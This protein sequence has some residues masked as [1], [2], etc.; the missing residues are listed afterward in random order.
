TASPLAQ[1]IRRWQCGTSTAKGFPMR[2][3]QQIAIATLV[4][5]QL[6]FAQSQAVRRPIDVQHST[7]TV[8]AFKAGLFS[9]FAD[10]HEISAPI[11]K[12]F[13]DDSAAAKVDFLVEVSSMKVLD[14]KLPAD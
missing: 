8:R 1:K 11:S 9:G 14:P 3:I 12:G 7:L 2:C 5:S 4:V 13:I 6:S 10:D